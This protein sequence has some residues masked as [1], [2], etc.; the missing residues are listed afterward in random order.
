M[1]KRLRDLPQ[2]IKLE[3]AAQM[4]KVLLLFKQGKDPIEEVNHL[5]R[6]IKNTQDI[7]LEIE[8]HE[9]VRQY[10]MNDEDE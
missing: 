4:K 1:K 8:L 10:H 6:L 9:I 7:M 3:L 2:P 5:L